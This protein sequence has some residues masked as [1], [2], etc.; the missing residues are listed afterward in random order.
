MY[1]FHCGSP[2]CHSR[3]SAP[4]RD[5]LMRGVAEHVRTVHRIE[6]PTKSLLGYLEATAVTEVAPTRMAGG[7]RP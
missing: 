5:E 7:T 1:E 3:F 2:V 4:S 6:V